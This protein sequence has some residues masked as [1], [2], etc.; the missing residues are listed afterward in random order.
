MYSAVLDLPPR[1]PPRIVKYVCS[2]DIGRRILQHAR[3]ALPEFA[4]IHLA[5]ERGRHTVIV[6]DMDSL[7]AHLDSQ[8]PVRFPSRH[9]LRGQ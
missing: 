7:R 1:I 9:R 8:I 6:R 4:D 3:V 2:C 5:R